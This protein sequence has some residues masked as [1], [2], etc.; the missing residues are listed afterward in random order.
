[1][2]HP[3]ANRGAKADARVIAMFAEIAEIFA[4]WTLTSE[5]LNGLPGKPCFG[6]I[7]TM[8]ERGVASILHKKNY[9]HLF[10]S[11]EQFHCWV[12]LRVYDYMRF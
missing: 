10:C 4:E 7:R 8:H 2:S 1:M 3:Q 11:A 9:V 12:W 6:R 5:D